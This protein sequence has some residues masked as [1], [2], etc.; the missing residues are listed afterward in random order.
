[1]RRAGLLLAGSLHDCTCRCTR[2]PD[3]INADHTHKRLADDTVTD[4]L[5]FCNLEGPPARCC[6]CIMHRP[7][8]PR[9]ACLPAQQ[10]SC[11]EPLRA[12]T[13]ETTA[14]PHASDVPRNPNLA[15]T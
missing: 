11:S 10:P 5:A 6:P 4:Q 13:Q 14:R 3:E 1:M 9:P 15:V 8:L 7:V 12:V 2:T